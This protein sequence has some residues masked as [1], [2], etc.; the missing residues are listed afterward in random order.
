MQLRFY[1]SR[2]LV[3]VLWSHANLTYIK[4]NRGKE[5]ISVCNLSH[6]RKDRWHTHIILY[7]N[8]CVYV[9][10]CEFT[11]SCVY[12]CVHINIIQYESQESE[13]GQST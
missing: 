1:L 10:R 7:A 6:C 13:G 9:Y 11:H 4:C 8:M 3:P 2:E 12:I 5:T